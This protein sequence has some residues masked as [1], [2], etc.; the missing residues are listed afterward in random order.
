MSSENPVTGTS[1][2]PWVHGSLKQVD[3]GDTISV[4]TADTT[5]VLSVQAPPT[6]NQAGDT[7]TLELESEC[8]AYFRICSDTTGRSP[9]LIFIPSESPDHPTDSFPETATVYDVDL[10]GDATFG[11]VAE[12]TAR[13]LNIAPR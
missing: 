9:E 2:R 11:L 13:D 12:Q 4:T 1:M 3:I 6:Y 5:H 8:G 10:A 7:V